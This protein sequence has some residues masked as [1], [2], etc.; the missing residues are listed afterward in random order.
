MNQRP[1]ALSTHRSRSQQLFVTL[2]G[3]VLFVGP[4]VA[5]LFFG[6]SFLLALGLLLLGCALYAAADRYVVP[7]AQVAEVR[8]L[9]TRIQS[10]SADAIL[11]QELTPSIEIYE[12]TDGR[13]SVPALRLTTDGIYAQRQMTPW[14]QIRKVEPVYQFEP[15]PLLTN[16]ISGYVVNLIRRTIGS[17]MGVRIL[18]SS[19][20][21]PVVV[22]IDSLTVAPHLVVE[23]LQALVLKLSAPGFHPTAT[24]TAMPSQSTEEFLKKLSHDA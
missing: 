20:G 17:P 1:R 5:H 12:S 14:S 3:G 19:R 16:P 8:A 6:L 2:T 15:I 22:G 23:L 9:I 24:S 10:Q 21:T 13:N 18:S 11:S 7:R 4:I